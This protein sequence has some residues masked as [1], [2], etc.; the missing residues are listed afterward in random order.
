MN[1]QHRRKLKRNGVSDISSQQ[2]A[3]GLSTVQHLFSA[4]LQNVQTGRLSEAIELYQQILAAEP[5]HTASLYN[6]A[7]IAFQIGHLDD[8][9][10]LSRQTLGI[11]PNHADAHGHL[12]A[13]LAG[14]GKLVEAA[15]HAEKAVALNRGHMRAYKTLAA[16]YAAGRDIPRALYAIMR[17]LKVKETPQLK[18]MFVQYVKEATSSVPEGPEFRHCLVRA[19]SEPWGRPNVIAHACT[20]LVKHDHRINAAIKR[21]AKAWPKRL[22][23]CELFGADGFTAV[24]HDP[25]LRVLLE[26][27]RLPDIA[28]ECFLTTVRTELLQIAASA[29]REIMSDPTALD[30]FCALARQCFIN[31]Y[32]FAETDTERAV[33]DRLRDELAEAGRS[34]DN[35]DLLK[36]VAVAA[37]EPLHKIPD[38]ESLLTRS[39]PEAVD[40]LLTQQVREPVAERNMRGSMPRLTEID[41][42]VSV[43][44]QQQYEE[45]PYPRWVKT[46][47]EPSPGTI[48]RSLRAKFPHAYRPLE[49]NTVEALIA[50]CGTGQQVVDLATSLTDA[51]VLAVDLS[52]TSLC[53]AKYRTD[54]MGL[55]HIDYGQADILKLGSLGRSFDVIACTGVLHHLRDPLEG[56]RVLLSMLRAN[57]LMQIALYSE[58]ARA[59]VVAA[60]NFIAERGYG[61]SAPDIRRCRQ[62]IMRLDVRSPIAPVARTT[63]F[64]GTSDCRDLL[65]HVQEHRFTIPQIKTFL[66]E[67]GLEFL[68]FFTA[69]PLLR[70][71]PKMFPDDLA[72]TNL[73]NWHEFEMRHPM[74]F[75]SMYQFWVQKAG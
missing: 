45:N 2:S 41:D 20:H 73:D 71:Y 31:E 12:A 15:E 26:N 18:L 67:N 66:A 43:L 56:W 17:G 36:L 11:D 30:F 38:C 48:D 9:I 37:Y 58:T 52:L 40:A 65:F 28:T 51:R 47:P 44:V 25:L 32:V 55:N 69:D 8:A 72:R 54:A 46:V 35:I 16:I 23:F 74:A 13:A 29:N 61:V 50:G 7:V 6:L 53:Y 21:A 62:D 1:R 68:G 3:R 63:D 57:G 14:Q 70:E 4:A 49:K 60:R 64:F 33:V 19:L 24:I 59:S 27:G 5:R 75:A 42:G 34:N 22:T 39:W 10:N